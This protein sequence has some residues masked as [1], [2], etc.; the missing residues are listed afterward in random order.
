MALR[1]IKQEL[2]AIRLEEF[3]W[4]RAIRIRGSADADDALVIRRSS[5]SRTSLPAAAEHPVQRHAIGG[6]GQPHEDQ[7]LFG[8]VE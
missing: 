6:V 3:A 5:R 4:V 7:L 2:C 1:V 8:K